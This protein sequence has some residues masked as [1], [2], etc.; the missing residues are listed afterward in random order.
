MI[1]LDNNT[2]DVLWARN[3]YRAKELRNLE[4][5]MFLTSGGGAKIKNKMGKIQDFK[6]ANNDIYLFFKNG[7][8]ITF[9]YS[10]GN[11]KD[12]KKISKNG[13][14]TR[15]VFLKTNMFLIDNDNKLL[16]FN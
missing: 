14:S 8:L 10:N 12:L 7:Y 11:L 4:Q 16:K 3:I 9:D 1:C 15:V 5:R 13:I 2:G 6:I